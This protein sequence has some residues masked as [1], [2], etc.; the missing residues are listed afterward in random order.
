VL[1]R[2]I[3]D[4]LTRLAM[5]FSVV[6]QLRKSSAWH[7]AEV[8]RAATE[9]NY[10]RR[11]AKLSLLDH[12]RIP[13]RYK[14]ESLDCDGVIMELSEQDNFKL[15]R[16]E[17]RLIAWVR[18]RLN[19]QFDATMWLNA[20]LAECERQ[21]NLL[22]DSFGTSKAHWLRIIDQMQIIYGF[23]DPELDDTEAMQSGVEF[24]NRMQ[25]VG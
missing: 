10:S 7:H 4:H 3:M 8:R 16:H 1:S 11:Q 13:Y 23:F 9:L 15:H 21:Y 19:E 6:E 5:V 14:S 25:G 24:S 12:C 20:V 18:D 22:P 2:P 17:Q